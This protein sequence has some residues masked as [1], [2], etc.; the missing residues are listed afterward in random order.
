MKK[1][2]TE[3]A[4]YISN[5]RFQAAIR[6]VEGFMWIVDNSA[7]IIDEQPYWEELTGQSFEEYYG[8]GW[9]QA[10]HPD[11]IKDF[12]KVVNKSLADGTPFE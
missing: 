10:V 6:A 3:E 7:R 12:M 5:E 1:R 8:F 11:N 4:L 9:K 2:I